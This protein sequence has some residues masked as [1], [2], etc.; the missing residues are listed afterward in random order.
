MKVKLK[1]TENKI[2]PGFN[3]ESYMV[4]Y[5]AL[6]LDNQIMYSFFNDDLK[7]CNMLE[8]SLIIIDDEKQILYKE[9]NLIIIERFL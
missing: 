6:C 1:N 4:I 7:V 2:M 9:M 5:Y 3:S 8:S